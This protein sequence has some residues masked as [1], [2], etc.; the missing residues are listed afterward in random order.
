[1]VPSVHLFF[2]SSFHISLGLRALPVHLLSAL[3]L[4]AAREDTG[5]PKGGRVGSVVLSERHELLDPRGS[6]GD[7][8]RLDQA[9]TPLDRC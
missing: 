4:R 1:M 8:R 3:T 6:G 9:N 7:P 5:P 2:S